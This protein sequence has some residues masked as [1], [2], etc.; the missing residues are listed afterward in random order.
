[1]KIM[2]PIPKTIPSPRLD[3]HAYSI[4]IK[5]WYV[6]ISLGLETYVSW[7]E[8]RNQRATNRHWSL[9]KACGSK[10]WTGGGLQFWWQALLP[11]EPFHWPPAL[12]WVQ[13]RSQRAPPL[14]RT[15]RCSLPHTTL[16]FMVIFLQ[17]TQT[18]ASMADGWR[19]SKEP[20]E[21]QHSWVVW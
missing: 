10:D 19:V 5:N 9:L 20:G 18:G 16:P 17:F 6:F 13:G 3:L 2:L 7:F 8:C 1:M 21:P 12:L 4:L 14:G 15:I 11:T